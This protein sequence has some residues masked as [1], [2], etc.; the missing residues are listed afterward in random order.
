VRSSG[1]KDP[2]HPDHGH[3]LQAISCGFS[4]I[5]QPP[6]AYFSKSISL[7]G[8]PQII[9]LK[10]PIAPHFGHGAVLNEIRFLAIVLLVPFI[11]L[12]WQIVWRIDLP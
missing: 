9:R 8:I 1:I 5:R 2:R 10:L 7:L 4:G 11:S 3:S 12:S 6:I